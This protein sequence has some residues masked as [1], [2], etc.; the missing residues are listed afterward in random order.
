MS[1]PNA[2][3]GVLEIVS[4]SGGTTETR[5]RLQKEAFLLLALGWNRLESRSFEYHHYG[6]YSR[7]LSDALRF[8]IASGYLQETVHQADE[9]GPTKYSYAITSLGQDFVNDANNL[10]DDSRKLIEI[11]NFQH[12]R[13]LELAATVEFLQTREGFEDRGAAFSEALR[14]KP[15]TEKFESRALDLLQ[16]LD[17]VRS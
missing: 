15:A 16:Q 6:P 12:W 7:K 17:Q 4:A 2:V 13:T 9:S 11:M 8:A 3:L 14:L 10:S 5:I 1:L